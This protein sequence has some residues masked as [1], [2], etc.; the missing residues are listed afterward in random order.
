M[1]ARPFEWDKETLKR[2]RL[3][4]YISADAAVAVT[5]VLGAADAG[6]YMRRRPKEIGFNIRAAAAA[7]EPL[8]IYTR[9]IIICERCAGGWE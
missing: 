3:G 6:G 7:A 2:W 8:R 1:R 5:A 9:I 4:Q